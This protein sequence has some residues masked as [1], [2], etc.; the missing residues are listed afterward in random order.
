MSSAPSV[1][2]LMLSEGL[3]HQGT[4]CF[5]NLHGRCSSKNCI[6]VHIDDLG[7]SDAVGKLAEHFLSPL[8][9]PGKHAS[10]EMLRKAVS[11]ASTIAKDSLRNGGDCETCLRAFVSSVNPMCLPRGLG[12]F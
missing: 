6:D 12:K 2:M 10:A 8:Y 4:L 9:V 1:R 5:Q 7:E 11:A 3:G